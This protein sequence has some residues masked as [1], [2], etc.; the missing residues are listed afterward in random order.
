VSL[1][2]SLATRSSR[3][4]RTPCARRTT[5]WISAKTARFAAVSSVSSMIGTSTRLSAEIA[6]DSRFEKNNAT[7]GVW[8]N[9]TAVC[10]STL[11]TWCNGEKPRVA[12]T[13][14]RGR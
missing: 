3:R 6:V 14:R 1:S 2:G 5:A 12:R 4:A 9:V 11:R 10:R 13:V 7:A 8:S